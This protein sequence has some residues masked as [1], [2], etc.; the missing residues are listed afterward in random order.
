MKLKGLKRL[1]NMSHRWWNQDLSSGLLTE[2]S[3]GLFIRL[4]LFPIKLFG[5]PSF[6]NPHSP[7]E[8]LFFITQKTP[9]V[10][11]IFCKKRDIDNF[12]NKNLA[13]AQI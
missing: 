3:L 8:T 9:T 10:H 11:D 12:I 6:Y 4:A 13:C 2:K 7:S 1:Y 5:V